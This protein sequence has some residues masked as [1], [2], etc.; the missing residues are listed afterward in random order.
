MNQHPL[1]RPPS[2]DHVVLTD[3]DKRP[4]DVMTFVCH[5][6]ANVR[7]NERAI[8]WRAP[9]GETIV[10]IGFVDAHPWSPSHKTTVLLCDEAGNPRS[11][12]PQPGSLVG[13]VDHRGAAETFWRLTAPR[14]AKW[15][16][17][18]EPLAAMPVTADHAPKLLVTPELESVLQLTLPWLPVSVWPEW[19]R[20]LYSKRDGLLVYANGA[21]LRS[22]GKSPPAGIL[23]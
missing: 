10:T 1:T 15:A 5:A 9:N 13:M 23:G 14:R 7:D 12:D 3:Y 2:T 6:P 22:L 21:P 20:R 17:V 18:L 8:T 11:G 16:L 4:D 19:C